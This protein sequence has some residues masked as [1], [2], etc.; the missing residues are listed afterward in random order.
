M[1]KITIEIIL[2]MYLIY[3]IYNTLIIIT[4]GN[5]KYFNLDPKRQKNAVILA[6]MRIILISLA[7]ISLY[8]NST[9]VCL[10]FIFL[11]VFH[12][13]LAKKINIII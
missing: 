2:F 7:L 9:F 4:L 13:Q 12:I 6:F 3:L 10:A 8:K 1:F 5:G 11:Y